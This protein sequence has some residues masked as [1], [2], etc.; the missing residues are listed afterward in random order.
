MPLELGIALSLRYQRRGSGVPHNWVALVPEG[1]VHQRFL[2]DLA[3]F[4]PPSHDETPAGIIRA[5]SGWLTIQ[6]DYQP[7]TPSPRTILEAYPRLAELLDEARA[8]E[9]GN[10]TWPVI[11]RNVERIISAI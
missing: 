2:S 7:P 3:G 11:I 4:D 6:P 1:F 9:L 5:I 8:E 10:L